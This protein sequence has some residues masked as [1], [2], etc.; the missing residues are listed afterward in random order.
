VPEGIVPRG[1]LGTWLRRPWVRYVGAG[2]ITAVIVALVVIPQFRNAAHDVGLLRRIPIWWILVGVLLEAASFAAY[3]LFTR[4]VLP[5]RGRPSYHRLLRIDVIGSGLTHLLPGGGAAASGLRYRLLRD[6]GVGG[7]DAGFG[8]VVQG[9]GSSMVVSLILLVGLMFVLPSRGGNP[10]YLAAAAVCVAHLG[11]LLALWLALSRAEE[12]TMRLLRRITAWTGRS[13]AV[14]RAMR[15]AAVRLH[16]MEDN[17]R[18]LIGAM[19]W[20]TANWLLDAASLWVFLI[21]FGYRVDLG[22][23]LLAFG[24]AHTLAILPITPGGVGIVE[25]TLVSCLV[26]AGTPQSVALLGVLTWR[27]FNFWAPIP[28]GALAWASLGPSLSRLRRSA[29]AVGGRAVGGG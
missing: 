16:Q 28:A 27:L 9:L 6:S 26:G 3:G 2:T 18:Q 22:D 8:S 12:R 23:M 5:A 25:G 14:E 13:A 10:L 20:S 19:T 4:G 1:R 24:L 11:F 15:G 29:R 7:A 21:A 17:P